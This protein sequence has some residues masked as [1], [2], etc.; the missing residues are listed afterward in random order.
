MKKKKEKKKSENIFT[1][2]HKE[3]ISKIYKVVKKNVSYLKI[4]NR[5]FEHVPH[6]EG[7]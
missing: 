1:I 3:L 6:K 2:I 7:H 4:M 5:I